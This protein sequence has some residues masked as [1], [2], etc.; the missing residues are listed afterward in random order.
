M[1]TSS[2]DAWVRQIADLKISLHGSD[3]LLTWEKTADE[4][5]AVCRLA[6]LL[7]E[8]HRRRVSFRLFDGGL[9]VSIF[10]DKST[11]TRF[12]FASAADALGLT[13]ADLDEEKTQISHG[14]STRETAAMISFL[15]EVVG[16]RDDKF[17]GEGNRYMR[18]FA[19]AIEES[20]KDDILHQRPP[21]I[22]LQCDLDH[23]T[24]TISDL[25]MLKKYFGSFDE[26]RGKKIAVSWAYS[27][28]YAKP[29]SVPQ[30]LIGLLPRFGMNVV[31]A[32]PKG[33]DLIPEMM[34][35][36]MQNASSGSGS[37]E[38]TDSMEKAFEQADVVYPKSWSPY[39]IMKR[40]TELLKAGA[41]ERLQELEQEAL[42]YNAKFKT[43]ECNASRMSRTRD[44]EA[45]YMHCLP[46]DITG[47]NCENGEVSKQIFEKYRLSTYEEAGFKPFVIAAMI[48]LTTRSDPV[49]DLQTVIHRMEQNK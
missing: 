11:R 2:L 1:G 40:R 37:F 18:E 10:R 32:Y 23:P 29:L 3:F 19:D 21:V 30:G 31:L 33:Y 39:H 13:V 27:P 48:W 7:K 22:N 38:V 8:L 36:A 16:I 49:A 4:I 28:S 44:G 47:V 45:L 5:L 12:S 34:N 26:L 35:V 14:E 9:A 6:E 20:Y 41:R 15:T 42:A 46:A 25:L 43:W 17:L 24:Q